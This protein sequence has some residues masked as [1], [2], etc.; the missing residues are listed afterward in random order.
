MKKFFSA[1]ILCTALAVL[2]A[3]CVSI[4]DTTT[5][6]TQIPNP[7]TECE[8]MEQ[9][10][11]LTGF[12][13]TVPEAVD[14]YEEKHISVIS[15]NLIQ[16]R[17]AGGEQELLLR[18]AKGTGDCSGDYNHYSETAQTEME[19]MTVTMKGE[20]GTVRLAL[21]THG[22]FSYSIGC[23]AGEVMTAEAL[24]ALLAQIR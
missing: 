15:D 10:K 8:T 2:F 1:V 21:W 6:Q 3:A 17:F 23:Y 18:K 19:G 5:N 13:M 20:P 22:G 14:G 11:A 9:A 12:E 4:K 16:V 24:T 7:I